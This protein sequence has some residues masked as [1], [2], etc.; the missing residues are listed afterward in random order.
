MFKRALEW[1]QELQR[2]NLNTTDDKQLLSVLQ[3]YLSS[4]EMILRVQALMIISSS[5]K[6]LASI[7]SE[8]VLLNSQDME[9][10]KL[11]LSCEADFSLENLLKLLLYLCS[12]SQ[13]VK[14]MCSHKL[15]DSLSLIFET[16]KNMEQEIA[17]QLIQHILEFESSFE[18]A[19]AEKVV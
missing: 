7:L 11:Q 14:M 15:L 8:N 10:I 9:Y 2:F 16:D 18:A 13:N 1:L 19:Q 6:D 12:L 5:T 3:P 17:A 4:T